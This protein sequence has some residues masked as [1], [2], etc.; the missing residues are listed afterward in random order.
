M[1]PVI[2][3]MFAR[4]RNGWSPKSLML[5]VCFVGAVSMPTSRQTGMLPDYFSITWAK[6]G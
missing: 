3:F 1:H 6:E 4:V 2:H 5:A